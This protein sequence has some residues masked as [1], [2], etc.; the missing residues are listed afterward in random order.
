[1]IMAE[2]SAAASGGHVNE[3]EAEPVA[4]RDLSATSSL[5]EIV[6]VI[7]RATG[8]VGTLATAGMNPIAALTAVV[9]AEAVHAG[10]EAV[11]PAVIELDH[12]AASGR[13]VTEQDASRIAG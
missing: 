8:V 2:V 13:P 9:G 3:R 12:A 4:L 6:A 11:V 7:Q 1:P 5:E 10:V